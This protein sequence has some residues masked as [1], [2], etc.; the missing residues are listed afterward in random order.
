MLAAGKA[1][2][3][4]WELAKETGVQID[5]NAY[6][7]AVR[8][9]YSLPDGRMASMPFNSSTAVMWINKDAFR[10]AGLDPD[11]P[12]ATWQDVTKRRPRRIKAKNAAPV[13]MNTSWLDLGP[14][15]A[16]QRHPQP[17]LR[18]ARRTGSTALD[19]QLE[20]Q[21]ASRT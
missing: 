19:A 8:G 3:Q 14:V 18:H 5:P 7:P 16:V 20:I 2:K 11:K 6:I 12:P 4:V 13:P 10:K 1:V 21:H 15:G 9:Y 17:A